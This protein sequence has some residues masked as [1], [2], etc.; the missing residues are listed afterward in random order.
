MLVSDD[1]LSLF[2]CRSKGGP[3]FKGWED[4][5]DR[6]GEGDL[7]LAVF[8]DLGVDSSSPISLSGAPCA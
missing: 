5:F 2:L 7:L 8:F 1:M 3:K 4:S 6:V